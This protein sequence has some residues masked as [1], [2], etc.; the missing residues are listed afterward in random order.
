MICHLPTECDSLKRFLI[1][2]FKEFAKVDGSVLFWHLICKFWIIMLIFI[3]TLCCAG[4]GKRIFPNYRFWDMKT[5]DCIVLP[6]QPCIYFIHWCHE[7]TRMNSNNTSELLFIYF[8]FNYSTVLT[9]VFTYIQMITI[10]MSAEADI[11]DLFILDWLLN[12]EDFIG[13]ISVEGYFHWM[14]LSI[15]VSL[16]MFWIFFPFR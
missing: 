10:D 14:F 1:L 11:C 5:K 8:C 13:W 9:Q 3:Y 16:N 4:D 2:N 12:W 7:K 15:Y 6:S